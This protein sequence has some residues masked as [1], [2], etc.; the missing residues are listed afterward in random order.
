MRLSMEN[1]IRIPTGH[2]SSQR[3]VA[4]SESNTVFG[5]QQLKIKPTYWL[6]PNDAYMRK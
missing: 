5:K 1:I 6:R 4:Y 3:I 2:V